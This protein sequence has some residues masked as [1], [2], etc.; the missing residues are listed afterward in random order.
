MP[1]VRKN[2]RPTT[3][4][5]SLDDI[6]SF[7]EECYLSEAELGEFLIT[8]ERVYEKKYKKPLKNISSLSALILAEATEKE[9]LQLNKAVTKSFERRFGRK[10]NNPVEGMTKLF[11]AEMLSKDKFDQLMDKFFFLFHHWKEAVHALATRQREI[12]LRHH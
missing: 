2:N 9:M 11:S 8:M 4:N 6:Y 12:L 10:L 3:G 5:N 7:C 1:V